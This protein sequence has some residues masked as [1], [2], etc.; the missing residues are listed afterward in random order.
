MAMSKSKKVKQD[1]TPYKNYSKYLKSVDTSNV[2]NTLGNLTSYAL[3]Q[4]KNLMNNANWYLPE[5]NP[6]DWTLSVE[7]SDDARQRAEEATFN[8][9]MNYLQPQ[10][11]QER[12]A[13]GRN[14][15]HRYGPDQERRK[16]A[17]GPDRNGIL[18]KRRG[19]SRRNYCGC[20]PPEIRF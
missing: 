12:N 18:S 17:E 7:A 8:S 3:G 4:S 20:K 14:Y 19:N 6:D 11:E 15:R 9:V 16:E 13:P 10:F 1:T 2:D 5:V